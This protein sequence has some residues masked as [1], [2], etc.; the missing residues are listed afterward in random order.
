VTDGSGNYSLLGM[1]QGSYHMY[2]SAWSGN[3]KYVSKSYPGLVTIEASQDLIGLDVQLAEGGSVSG[4]VTQEGSAAPISGLRVCAIDHEGTTGRCSNSG[5]D[6][7]YRLNG[8]PTGEYSVEFEGGNAVNYLYE[9]YKDAKTWAAAEKVQVEAPNLTPGIDA[10]LAPGAEILGHVSEVGSG[11]PMANVMVC[12]E[13]QVGEFQDCEWT[14]SAGG[15]ALRS[16]P[17]GTYLVAFGIEFL[18]ILGRYVAQWWQGAFS[19]AEATPIAIAP[20]ETRSGIDARLPNPY[21]PH[22]ESV[23]KPESIVATILPKPEKQPAKCHRRF[24][25]KK[26]HGK[27]RCVR[28][29]RR[30]HSHR[31]R[32]HRVAP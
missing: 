19:E 26:V 17:A 10:V 3:L 13:A 1:P 20:P 18:P 32:G 15:Y 16:L 6:G 21:E 23:V 30:P 2:F 25:R 4:L 5:S 31:H 14:D 11:A 9:F 28:K 7:G 27:S 12:A 22:P 29:H 24:H 8:L